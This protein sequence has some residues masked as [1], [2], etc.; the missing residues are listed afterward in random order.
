LRLR[1][2]HAGALKISA[3]ASPVRAQSIGRFEGITTGEPIVHAGTAKPAT[4][5]NARSVDPAGDERAHHRAI[6]FC[7]VPRAG[8]SSKDTAS[9]PTRNRETG[10]RQPGRDEAIDNRGTRG[11]QT[12]RGQVVV[13]GRVTVNY[14]ILLVIILAGAVCE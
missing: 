11:W 12:D 7:L 4:T 14:A 10:R 3:K 5:L 6:D 2:R 1:A 9:V 8:P 13:V